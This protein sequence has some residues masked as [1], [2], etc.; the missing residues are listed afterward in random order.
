MSGYDHAGPQGPRYDW[1]DLRV[2]V[3]CPDATTAAALFC[4]C[5]GLAATELRVLRQEAEREAS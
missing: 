1:D 3:C 4:G 2:E 5:R